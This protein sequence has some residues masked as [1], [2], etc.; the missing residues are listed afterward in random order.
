MVKQVIV[1]RTDLKMRKGKMIA[2]GSHASL[3]IFLD[4]LE[5]TK[6]DGTYQ[7]KLTDEMKSW[8]EGLYTKICV[9]V[10]S[11]DELLATYREA[12]EKG[13]PVVLITDSGLT[14]FHGVPTNTCICIGPGSVE[15]INA[16]T[17]HLKL[18]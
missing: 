10:S 9:G 3:K 18:L 12:E 4:R 5:A 14:E 2:Q 17:G 1:M 15:E 8:M 16:I 6:E 11:E 13:L 7:L